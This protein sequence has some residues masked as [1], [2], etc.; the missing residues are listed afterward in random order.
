MKQSVFYM[1]TDDQAVSHIQKQMNVVGQ[2]ITN[3]RDLLKTKLL[4]I[5]GQTEN[6]GDLHFK[7]LLNDPK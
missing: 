4:S 7:M 3:P 6:T 1:A 5:L 2:D